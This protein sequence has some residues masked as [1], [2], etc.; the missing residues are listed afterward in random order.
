MKKAIAATNAKRYNSSLDIVN[1]ALRIK[2]EDKFNIYMNKLT[3]SY[4][5]HMAK[6]NRRLSK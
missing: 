3:Q 4:N 6:L 5:R 1:N 2:P